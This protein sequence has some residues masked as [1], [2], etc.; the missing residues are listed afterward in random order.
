MNCKN[1]LNQR[2]QTQKTT[3]CVTL[4]EIPEEG[5]TMDVRAIRS[6]VAFGVRQGVSGKENKG[7]FWGDDNVL[8]LDGDFSHLFVY[9]FVQSQHPYS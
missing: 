1:M 3:C 2:S 9:V 5:K 4:C 7:I 8:Y 6:V